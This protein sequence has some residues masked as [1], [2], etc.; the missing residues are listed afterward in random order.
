M[1]A[2]CIA[3]QERVQR[4]AHSVLEDAGGGCTVAPLGVAGAASLDGSALPPRYADV[5]TLSAPPILMALMY[6]YTTLCTPPPWRTVVGTHA[7]LSPPRKAGG[8][9]RDLSATTVDVNTLGVG[10]MAAGG[11]VQRALHEYYTAVIT[12]KFRSYSTSGGGRRRQAGS[13]S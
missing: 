8:L 10:A 11:V 3:V 4:V 12:K 6:M 13:G 2:T 1:Y 7:D 5:L 9:A